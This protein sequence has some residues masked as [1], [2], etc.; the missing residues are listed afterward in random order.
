MER[1]DVRCYGRRCWFWFIDLPCPVPG[2]NLNN[3]RLDLAGVD[4]QIFD[5]RLDELQLDEAFAAITSNRQGVSHS[6]ETNTEA[7]S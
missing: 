5:G 2:P 3:L 7:A 6:F 1:T 4:A